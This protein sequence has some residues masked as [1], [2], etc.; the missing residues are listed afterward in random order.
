MN[1][2]RELQIEVLETVDRH[3]LI[4]PN[5]PDFILKDLMSYVPERSTDGAA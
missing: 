1:F 4:E 5:N 3:G 2:N